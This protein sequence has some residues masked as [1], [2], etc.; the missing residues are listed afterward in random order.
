M[1]FES[2]DDV[3]AA[4]TRNMKQFEGRPIEIQVGSGSTLY[5]ANFPPTADES[6]VRNKFKSVSLGFFD[7]IEEVHRMMKS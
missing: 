4:Q 6:W 7:T 2:K 3:L 1:E 5:V